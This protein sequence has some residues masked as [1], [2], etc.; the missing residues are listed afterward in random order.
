[1]QFCKKMLAD[2][3]NHHGID[4]CFDLAVRRHT[5]LRSTHRRLIRKV[6]VCSILAGITPS[7]AEVRDA[8]F[9]VWCRSCQMVPKFLDNVTTN[10][11]VL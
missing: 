10:S 8:H 7:A 5:L 4:R 3:G 2:V 1:M 11:S 9:M 6:C